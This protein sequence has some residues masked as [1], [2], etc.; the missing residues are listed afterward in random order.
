MIERKCTINVM[1]LNHP[2]AIPPPPHH[3]LGKS[4]LLLSWSLVPKVLGIA[5]CSRTSDQTWVA[6][7]NTPDTGLQLGWTLMVLEFTGFWVYVPLG[8][9]L[10]LPYSDLKFS[11]SLVVLSSALGLVVLFLKA[12]ST[13]TRLPLF[14]KH[15]NY[16]SNPGYLKKD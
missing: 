12:P 1:L 6:F 11:S 13:D 14:I 15:F 4:C 2:Q 8:T 3:D 9:T 7:Y 5:G 16:I 10:I